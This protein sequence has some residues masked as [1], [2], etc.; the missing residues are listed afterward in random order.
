MKTFILISGKMR[1]GKNQFADFLSIYLMCKGKSVRQDLF[2]NDLKKGCSEDF[3]YMMAQI[4]DQVSK[5]K[6]ELCYSTI[7]SKSLEA[8]NGMLDELTVKHNDNWYENKTLISRLLLQTYGTQ[9]FRDRVNVNHWVDQVI[10]RAIECDTD[11]TLVTDAR[12][13]NEI[14]RVKESCSNKNI[15]VIS[16]RI[17]RD[18]PQNNLYTHDSEKGLDNFKGWDYTIN[19]DGSF[20]DLQKH[21]DDIVKQLV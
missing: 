18:I 19:N 20:E 15:R 21:A 10:N 3:A 7:D 12:F 8:A 16:I 14:N 4:N 5:I 11:F 1:S 6:E 9:I 17:E 2:A 13:E